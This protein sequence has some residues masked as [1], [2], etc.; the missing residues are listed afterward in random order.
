MATNGEGPARW[1]A[2]R[3]H[4][5]EPREKRRHPRQRPPRH[6]GQG[7]RAITASKANS[8]RDV[9]PRDGMGS[10][11]GPRNDAN[12]GRVA[13]RRDAVIGLMAFGTTRLHD[14]VV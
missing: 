11:I 1:I 13:S 4:R 14:A 8:G 7:V 6:R 10:S 3:R 2:P 9:R 12:L 5:A